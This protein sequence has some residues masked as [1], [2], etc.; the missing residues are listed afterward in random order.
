MSTIKIPKNLKI[1]I[2]RNSNNNFFILKFINKIGVI[3]KKIN[4]KNSKLSINF[5]NDSLVLQN[6][7][8]NNISLNNN[9]IYTYKIIIKQ[10]ILNLFKPVRDR[11]I[12][13]GVGY[14]VW[15]KKKNLKFKLGFSKPIF[16]KI[17]TGVIVSIYRLRK[18]AILGLS[19]QKLHIFKQKLRLLK[20]PDSYKKK[21]VRFYKE[22]LSFKQGKKTR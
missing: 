19:L 8:D 14:K 21:G 16:I 17:P 10:L 18:I 15:K 11:L 3:K 5:L 12:L 2:Y 4:N 7:S 6:K 22:I 20:E 13:E 9:S 1:Q